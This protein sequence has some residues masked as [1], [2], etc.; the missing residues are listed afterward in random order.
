ML[1][2]SAM[3]AS[4]I[5][6]IASYFAVPSIG[7]LYSPDETM[8]AGGMTLSVFFKKLLDFLQVGIPVYPDKYEEKGGNEIGTQV[9]VG[10]VGNGNSDKDTSKNASKSNASTATGALVKIMDNIVASP[11]SWVIHGYMGIN[12]ENMETTK[13]IT[14][15]ITPP[16]LT[17]FI[18]KFG[19][20]VLN[21]LMKKY[22]EYVSEARRPFKFYTADGENVAALIKNYSV[23]YLAENQNW[24]EVD[25]EI[26]EFRF[27]ALLSDNQQEMVGGVNSMYTSAKD[28]LR[29]LARGAVKALIF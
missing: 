19:R 25:L 4:A 15:A 3:L 26:Q 11:R 21:G 10:G 14:G 27:I 18:E 9:L 29:S 13:A 16:F 8:S 22:L 17:T 23:K 7:S 24:V 12:L 28:T 6:N 20:G 5:T 1:G 2:S